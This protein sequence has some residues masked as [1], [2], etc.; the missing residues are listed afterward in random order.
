VT[1]GA[2]R[3]QS[4]I[5][6]LNNYQQQGIKLDLDGLPFEETNEALRAAVK[7]A[8][9]AVSEVRFP[10]AGGGVPDADSKGRPGRTLTGIG[11][12]MFPV[13]ILLGLA[14]SNVAC[15][16]LQL[17]GGWEEIQSVTDKVSVSGKARPLPDGVELC[18]QV[19]RKPDVSEGLVEISVEPGK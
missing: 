6:A 16:S 11:S 5:N 19:R 4:R 13:L 14:F 18:L 7:K 1:R 10:G 3:V 9:S 2:K 12:T 8:S 17:P 15:S